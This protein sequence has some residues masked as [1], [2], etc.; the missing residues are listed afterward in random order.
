MHLSKNQED[1]WRDRYA[2]RDSEGNTVETSIEQTWSRIA[3]AIADNPG[4]EFDFYNILDGF[5]FVPGG[6]IIA[7]SGAEQGKTPYNCYVI[8]VETSAR[9]W[10]R[11]QTKY[12]L[13]GGGTYSPFA[14]EDHGNDSREAIFDTIG[15]MVSIMS[16]GGGVGINWSVLR[17]RG[18]YLARVSGTTSGPVPW[19]DVASR[20]V[21]VVEQGGS[22]RGAAM[23]MLDDWHPDVV[24][25]INAKRDM[26]M[27]TNANISV[28]V[29]DEFMEAVANDDEWEFRFPD[30]KD[31]AY[32]T[33]WD[34]D[35]LRWVSSGH[36]VVSH[37]SVNA[38]ELWRSLADSAWAS[39]EPG[40]VFLGRYNQLS[41]GAGVERI[42][43]VNPCGEQGLG[44]YSVCNLGAMNLDA[45]V[46]NGVFLW[47]RFTE[48]VET[49]IRFL[50]RVIDTSGHFIAETQ[51][52]Q[53]QLRRIGLG[54]M[55]L[56]DALV[57]LG[58]RYGSKESI[59]F[60]ETVFREMK[61]AA[62]RSS[63]YLAYEKGAARG[64]SDDMWKRP[65]LAEYLERWG[66]PLFEDAGMRNIFLLTQAP[67]GTTSL[68]A[69]VNSGIEP[70]FDIRTKRV[71]RTGERYVYAKAVQ[72]FLDSTGLPDGA[73]A[74][75]FIVTS[76]DVTVEEHIAI[77]AAVQKYV[78]SSVSKTINGPAEHTPEDVAKA[79]SLAYESGLK[80]LAYYRDGS[81]NVQVL[82][83]DTIVEPKVE[84]TAEADLCPDCDSPLAHEEGCKKCLSCGYSAC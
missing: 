58:M 2:L 79:Y 76:R 63:N 56:A 30:T 61:D 13:L 78:D 45:Y 72:D 33:E 60:V 47:G 42:I 66:H 81:R 48:D 21:G 43:C 6:R 11:Q 7:G 49:A 37:G 31:P 64:W 29:S 26:N 24:E 17:P 9:R 59:G 84:M 14:R 44:P 46:H 52:Q 28:A 39:G 75:D 23:F 74:P 4:D 15:T 57:R 70:Y 55:G 25:F 82:Y 35:L 71:D 18:T 1:I 38:R 3:K 8:P 69:G 22:R 12:E 34:G 5:H 10:N 20:A 27:I 51:Q 67:T 40:I 77:Q 80:G 73:E 53:D 65:Y 19:M 54:V 68:L 50:D 36:P 41:T 62:I 16:R 32:D 83:H